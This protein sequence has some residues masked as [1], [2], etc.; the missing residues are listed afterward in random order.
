[1]KQQF[2]EKEE[3]NLI[4]SSNKKNT[5]MQENNK[6]RYLLSSVIC[7]MNYVLAEWCWL[8]LLCTYS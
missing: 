3:K 7:K 4:R 2:S 1:M 5:I 6:I 8:H